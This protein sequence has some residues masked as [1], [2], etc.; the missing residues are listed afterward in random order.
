[1][2]FAKLN[3]MKGPLFL[4]QILRFLVLRLCVSYCSVLQCCHVFVCDV[5]SNIVLVTVR[6]VE[7][8]GDNEHSEHD[9]KCDSVF[10]TSC[11]ITSMC[12]Y[13]C[14]KPGSYSWWLCPLYVIHYSAVCPTQ[15]VWYIL[16][17]RDIIIEG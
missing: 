14:D 13:G 8:I 15:L 16:Q 10:R 6:R 9:T 11:R 7:D 3:C 1:M 17:V 5:S 2:W 12:P 4:H